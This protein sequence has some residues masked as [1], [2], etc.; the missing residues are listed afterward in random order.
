MDSIQKIKKLFYK[1]EDIE[2]RSR[3]IKQNYTRDTISSNEPNRLSK[4]LENL[5]KKK[6][7][8]FNIVFFLLQQFLLHLL[9]LMVDSFHQ[10]FHLS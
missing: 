9:L 2:R 1:Q 6:Y 3:V 5:D 10:F 7:S 8:S 4:Y